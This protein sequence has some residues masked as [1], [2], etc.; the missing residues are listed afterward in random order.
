MWENIQAEKLW[1]CGNI[2]DFRDA[3]KI[4]RLHGKQG[5]VYC[6][7][8]SPFGSTVESV[9]KTQRKTAS[10]LYEYDGTYHR[11][12]ITIRQEI[13]KWDTRRRRKTKKRKDWAGIEFH[14]TGR[15]GWRS[16]FVVVLSARR[17]RKGFQ[18]ESLFKFH[19]AP[20]DS[21]EDM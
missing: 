14:D 6:L 19:S 3:I 21:R 1:R 2:C 15:T 9:L 18:S 20:S 13:P 7:F 8:K 5:L 4:S 12:R 11:K 10:Q 17:K 16:T